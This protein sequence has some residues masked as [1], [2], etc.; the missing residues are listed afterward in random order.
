MP[1]ADGKLALKLIDYDG[2]YVPALAGT[3]SGELGHPNYQHPERLRRRAYNADVDR[4]SHLVIY[5]AVHCLLVGR[6]DLWQRFNNDE[7]LLFREQDFRRP[8][9]PN[10]SGPFGRRSD[11]SVRTAGRPPGAGLRPTA[12]KGPLA[13]QTGC[14]RTGAGIDQ[15]RREPGCRNPRRQESHGGTGSPAPAGRGPGCGGGRRVESPAP[16]APA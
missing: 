15:E 8:E 4:F 9:S 10:S 14:E 13:G 16:A 5:S 7:N 2:M 11:P 6:R 1:A 12:G 3:P